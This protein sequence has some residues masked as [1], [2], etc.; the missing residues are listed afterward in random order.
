MAN[1]LQALRTEIKSATRGETKAAIGSIRAELESIRKTLAMIERRL[2]KGAV[3]PLGGG[4]AMSALTK[5]A[6]GR[7]ARFSA[8]LMRKHREALAMSRKAYAKLLGVSGLSVYLWESG[9]TR[10]RRGTIFAWQ[11]LR[12]KGARELRAIAGVTAPARK[13]AAVKLKKAVKSARAAVAG[14]AKAVSKKVKR[15]KR[16]ARVAVRRPKTAKAAVKIKRK[17]RARRA[18]AAA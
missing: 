1:L 4:R 14:K 9:R 16:A 12:K 15:A 10:P 2:E 8:K 17:R 18:K 3:A 13:K 7:R 11:D 6:E 5:A